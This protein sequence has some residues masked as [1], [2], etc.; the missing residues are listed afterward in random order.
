MEENENRFKGFAIHTN[1]L[2]LMICD[3]SISWLKSHF[4]DLFHFRQ[5]LLTR[6]KS[7]HESLV[8]SSCWLESTYFSNSIVINF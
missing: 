5:T 6:F 1:L 4:S 7:N 8:F 3:T 2:Y